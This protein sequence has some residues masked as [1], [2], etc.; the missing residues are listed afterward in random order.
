MSDQ[1][2]ILL[3]NR[4]SEFIS[5]TAD[6][7]GQAGY[8]VHTSME[9]RGALT[10][11]SDHP[12]SLIICDKDLQDISGE[13]FLSFIKKDP[14]RES[15]PFVFFV[16]VHDQGR[17]F[18]AFELGAIDFLVYPMEEQDLVKRI[19]EIISSQSSEKAG[20]SS[21]I[22]VADD[23]K[24][25]TSPT[26]PPAPTTAQASPAP[27]VP[28]TTPIPP[29]SP[30]SQVPPPPIVEKRQRQR[31]TL[32]LSLDIEVSRDGVL[33]F[34]GKIKNFNQEG[35]FVETS[36]F[37][38]A[39]VSLM[40]RFSQPEGTVVV[41]GRIKHVSIDS[42]QAPAGTG[43]EMDQE[44][45]WKKIFE[46]LESGKVTSIEEE[47]PIPQESP[48][49]PADSSAKVVRLTSQ[50]QKGADAYSGGM[51][52]P[53]EVDESSYD[54]RFY[55]SLVGKQL[56]NYRT[57]TFI[58][59]GSMGGVFQGWD[60]ALEREVALKVI[61]YELSSQVAFRDMFIK[62]AR[63]ISRL[64]HPHIAQIYHIGGSE[65]ILYYA[66]EFIDGETLSELMQRE[67]S[68]E[69]LKG[70]EYLLTVCET[71]DFISK[72]NI[73]HRDIKPGN[74]MLNEKG[75]IKVVDFGVAKVKD[76]SKKGAG[77]EAI[78]GSPLYI[79]P[80]TLT[81]R[82]LDHRSDI[83][84]LG[85]TFYHLFTG[86]PPFEGDSVQDIL[87]QHLTRSLI[88]MREKNSS[89]SNALGKII[90]KMM[91]KDPN[92]RYQDYQSI[93]NEFKSLRFRA[94][95]RMQKRI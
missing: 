47:T 58:G 51:E 33:W 79:S 90:E 81:G 9:M 77:Q 93:I 67:G 14:L 1:K 88:P 25:I 73:I 45:A 4:D 49:A 8:T 80:D 78:M 46:E 48:A 40:I 23:A 27:P 43:I 53:K 54:A 19:G 13:N 21:G 26:P 83:Y 16:P 72:K 28:T 37:G 71:L 7:L 34:P 63:V 10:A 61:S 94:L 11:L 30:A 39:G 24:S 6:F 57:I 95:N 69:T 86:Y 55:Y 15:I 42:F 76:A 12:V 35:I 65:D 70:I 89:V 52:S 32:P 22:S 41:N 44:E 85:A 50:P 38:K 66:M 87:D 62:E 18:K 92:E 60:V 31:T 68:L 56:D 64:D 59:S 36:L 74:I 84:S 17:A 20:K 2:D 75:D 91:A 3:I 82:D 5:Q 29:T